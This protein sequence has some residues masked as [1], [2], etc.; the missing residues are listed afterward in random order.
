MDLAALETITL[1]VNQ[2]CPRDR[3]DDKNMTLN[4]IRHFCAGQ[5]S[6]LH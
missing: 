2:V 3:Q 5:S 4:S 6:L 1:A